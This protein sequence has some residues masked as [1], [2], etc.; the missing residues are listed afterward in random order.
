LIAFHTHTHTHTQTG[1]KIRRRKNERGEKRRE[2]KESDRGTEKRR[3]FHGMKNPL[4]KTN[5]NS[6]KWSILDGLAA[7]LDPSREELRWLR[8]LMISILDRHLILSTPTV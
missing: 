2:R 8:G 7:V 4:P 1:N 3:Q 6:S 5:A